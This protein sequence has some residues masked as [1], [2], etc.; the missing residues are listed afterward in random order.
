MP[1]PVYRGKSC[2]GNERMKKIGFIDY[3]ID[4]WHANHY[5]AWIRQAAGTLGLDYE[6]AYAYATEDAPGGRTTGAWCREYGT[7]PCR[8]IP[9]ICER[10]DVLLILAPSDP[11]THL[12]FA[13]AVL[14]YG[15]PT[16]IDKTFAPDTRTA[17]AI[18]DLAD[19]YRTPVFSS[20]ALRYAS[21]L[22]GM[23]NVR[24]ILTCGGGSNAPEY[25]IHQ[26]EMVIR[27][28]K[29]EPVRFC[30]EPQGK[31]ILFRAG[32]RSGSTASMIYAPSLPFGVCAETATG[33][34]TYSVITSDTFGGLMRDILRFYETG[35]AG[36][37]RSETMYVMKLR[38]GVLKALSAPETWITTT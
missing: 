33:E 37:D 1:L 6:A 16:Y 2:W 18:F 27:L 5:P 11:Q 30:A 32:F 21:E 36:F 7:I 24:H 19:H 20:S 25:I 22:D 23:K 35:T 14:P 26:A 15:K 9:E 34:E 10:S 3:R 17:Q 28:L 29:E 8:T 4:E 13:E 31:Q 12:P 38:E